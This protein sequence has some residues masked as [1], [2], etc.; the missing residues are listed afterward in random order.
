MLAP[1]AVEPAVDRGDHLADVEAFAHVQL[2]RETHLDVAHAFGQVVLRQLV[3]HPL[4]R[5][6]VDHHRAG[7]G[8][9]VQVVRQVFVLL[10]EDQLEQAF[11]GIGRQLDVAFF[12]ELD[13][14]REAEGAVEMYVEVGLG[15]RLQEFLGICERHLVSYST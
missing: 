8:E 9:A 3:G 12:G 7:V 15:D 11:R 1:R 13:Q 6:L 14:G 10:L 2:R 5:L 4:E